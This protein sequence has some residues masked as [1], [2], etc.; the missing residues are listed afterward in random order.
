MGSSALMTGL[1]LGATLI[2]A[3]S[4]QNAFVLRQGL[5][6]EHV[7]YIVLFCVTADAWCC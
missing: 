3:I 5:R 4:A 2:I 1:L 7:L 6:R